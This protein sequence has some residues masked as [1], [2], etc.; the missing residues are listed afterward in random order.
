M[1]R[2]SAPMIP[3]VPPGPDRSRRDF[4]GIGLKLGAMLVAAPYVSRAA[5]GGDT[6]NVALIGCGEQ[7]RVLLNAALKIPG[8]TLPRR[9]RHLPLQPPLRRA[10]AAEVRTRR[11]PFRGLRRR[12][13]HHDRPRRRARRDAGLRPRGTRLWAHA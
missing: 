1:N 8:D 12:A 4:V 13:V 7:G 11:P 10:S 9:L 5:T 2:E 6:L 3:S